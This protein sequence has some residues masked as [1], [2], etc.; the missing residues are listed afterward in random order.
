[1]LFFYVSNCK[2]LCV[3]MRVEMLVCLASALMRT[4]G[5]RRA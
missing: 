1:M 3:L 4:D 2:V 5:E